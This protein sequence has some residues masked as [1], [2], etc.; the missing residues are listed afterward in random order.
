MRILVVGQG[1][2]E[3]AIV[4]ALMR[5]SVEKVFAVPGS[6][7]MEAEGITIFPNESTDSQTVDRICKDNRIDLI[8]IGPEAP[9]VAGLADELRQLGWLVFGP[10]KKNA[11]LE[12][13]KVYAKQFMEKYA[14]PTSKYAVVESVEEV[15]NTI[16]EFTPPYVLKADGLA[17]GKGVFICN[18]SKSVLDAAQKIFVDK[19]FGDAG[20]VAILE[21]FQKGYELSFFVL[22][23]GL[24][25]V[26]L[27]MAQDHKKLLDNDLGPNTG[28]MGTV[29]PMEIHPENYNAIVDQVVLPSVNGLAE[30]GGQ[31]RG[32]LFIGLMM[33]D[34]GPQVLEYNIRFGDPE[35][36]VLLPLLDGDWADVFY[37]ISQGEV[38]ELKWQ[39]KAAACVVM[40]AEGYPGQPVKGVS[41]KGDLTTYD[42]NYFLHAGSLLKDH[43]WQTNGGRVLNAVAVES[44]LSEA[45]KVAYD[46][47]SNVTWPGMQYRKDIG[48]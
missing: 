18:D 15:K 32:V 43:V 34:E 17:A 47:I 44:T 6:D 22:T 20:K 19:I 4:K 38:P 40:A 2:R 27:P 16:E 11:Q 37:R 24:E 29:A 30:E 48:Q 41:I 21:Q 12:G 7:G 28:G 42:T 26:C 10:D 9:L 1:G 35:T 31:Y 36:Q 3:H 23:N 25:S 39:N 33:T 8:I 5:G 45:L 14:V 46:R 13:S